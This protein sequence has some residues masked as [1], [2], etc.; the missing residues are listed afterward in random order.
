MLLVTQTQWTLF[1]EPMNLQLDLLRLL[2]I[3]SFMKW[4]TNSTLWLLMEHLKQDSFQQLKRKM[5]THI[6]LRIL[7][8][9]MCCLNVSMQTQTNTHTKSF[10]LRTLKFQFLNMH[11]QQA[12]LKLIW[13]TLLQTLTAI[14]LL[15][16][17]MLTA[18]KQHTLM[19]QWMLLL[20]MLQLL[21]KKSLH[22][23]DFHIS[24][25]QVLWKLQ[26]MLM[27]Q[28]LENL[29]QT[30]IITWLVKIALMVITLLLVQILQHTSHLWTLMATLQSLNQNSTLRK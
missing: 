23:K 10:Q 28:L 2:T 21:T 3:W 25:L 19:N 18:I 29:V 27:Q 15:L 5:V 30:K 14:A 8:Q 9:V 7:V 13:Q 24:Q 12:L 20:D 16:K 4:I 17:R 26:T 11:C 1:I 22:Q 6:H